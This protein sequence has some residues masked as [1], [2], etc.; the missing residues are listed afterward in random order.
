MSGSIS[1]D[2][3]VGSTNTVSV[4]TLQHIPYV[5]S[6]AVG[7]TQFWTYWIADCRL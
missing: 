4:N 3:I 5:Q 6:T 2:T 1:A 7:F